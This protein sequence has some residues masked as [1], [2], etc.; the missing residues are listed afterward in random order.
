MIGLRKKTLSGGL[1]KGRTTGPTFP[2]VQL[3]LSYLVLPFQ[4]YG[5]SNLGPE[6]MGRLSHVEDTC[7]RLLKLYCPCTQCLYLYTCM[8][9]RS[10]ERFSVYHLDV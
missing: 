5:E 10:M 7:T 8:L 2:R 4:I 9:V 3:A 6:T 1:W